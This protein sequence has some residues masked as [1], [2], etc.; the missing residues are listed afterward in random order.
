MWNAVLILGMATAH[1]GLSTILYTHE[2]HVPTRA[3]TSSSRMVGTC[4]FFGASLF[5]LVMGYM[6]VGAQQ[7]VPFLCASLRL[8]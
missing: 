7:L 2:R 8:L 3:V 5:R 6:V 1:Q 4:G